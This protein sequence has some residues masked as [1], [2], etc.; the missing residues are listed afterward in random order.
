MNNSS[1]NTPRQANKLSLRL[2]TIYKVMIVVSTSM[3]IASIITAIGAMVWLHNFSNV[4][5]E[6]A[7]S[8]GAWTGLIGSIS[9][10]ILGIISIVLFI[11][12]IL[13]QKQLKD[14]TLYPTKRKASLILFIVS[15]LPLLIII[16]IELS[17]FL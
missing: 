4:P 1:S 13:L 10:I 5:I 12:R 9:V 14:A 17:R 16:L 2:Y 6:P 15:C 11:Y 7:Y 3:I 8:I